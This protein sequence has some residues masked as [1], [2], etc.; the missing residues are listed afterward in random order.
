MPPERRGASPAR[1]Q[2]GFDREFGLARDFAFAS[3]L[4]AGGETRRVGP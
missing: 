3:D 1:A 2:P 4:E